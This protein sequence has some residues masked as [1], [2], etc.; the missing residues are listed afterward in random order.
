MI[1]E[2]RRNNLQSIK[3]P[4][5]QAYANIYV[6]IYD[7][8]IEQVSKDGIEI[9][10][11]DVTGKAASHLESLEHKG[12]RL[13]NDNKSL[14]I[15]NISP[16][17]LA[18]QKGVGSATFFISLNC[19][20]S[21]FYCFN[22]N[23]QNY[24]HF[25]DNERDVIGEL[26]TYHKEGKK[27]DQ[28]ALTGGEPLL[29]VEEALAF[30]KTAKKLFPNAYTRL[31]TCG[32]ITSHHNL[33]ALK[34]AG[35]DEIRFSIRIHDLE[36]GQRQVFDRIAI[37]KQYIPFVMVEMPVLPGTFE[38]MKDVLRELDRLE[39]FSINLLEFCYPFVNTEIFNKRNYK[40]KTPPYRVLYNYWYA[41]G[42]PIAGSEL[43]CL[44]LIEFALE[45]GLK[46]GVHYCSLENKH[47]GQIYQQNY[48]EPIPRTA[49]LSQKDYFLKSA[50][51]FGDDIPTALAKFHQRKYDRYNLNQEHSFL[52]FH[53]GKIKL[54]E[55]LDIEI[56]ISTSVVENRNGEK[57]VR[58]L[59]VDLTTPKIFDLSAD[60]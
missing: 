37:A 3:N 17:C 27:L 16:A 6:G 15:N 20:R 12:A 34:Q 11:S 45:E 9:E 25:I 23:Q 19:H 49:Y 44:D 60:L 33:E 55:Q 56:G 32:D 59:K 7:N 50:K 46:I 26:E 22:S 8:F 35:L 57:V 18:C 43:D 28:I 21:C 39:I 5:F 24:A 13:R 30:F 40:I 10:P 47:S 36:K 29:H 1:T 52:E 2:I 31:Y 41:G 14:Y 51:V 48:G 38:I 53:I 58:E 42:L 54:L 4:T